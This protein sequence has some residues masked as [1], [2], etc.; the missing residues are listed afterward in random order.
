MKKLIALVIAGIV[1]ISALP[2]GVFAEG[3][4]AEWEI[5]ENYLFYNNDD[6]EK[7]EGYVLGK[8]RIG[9]EEELAASDFPEIEDKIIAIEAVAESDEYDVIFSREKFWSASCSK[10]DIDEFI[11]L[12]KRIKGSPMVYSVE[13]YK[14]GLNEKGVDEYYTHYNNYY[15]YNNE[16]ESRT[17]GGLIISIIDIV[18]TEDYLNSGAY[19]D[20]S[21]LGKYKEKF[22]VRWEQQND[23]VS[24]TYI[25]DGMDADPMVYTKETIDELIPI[26]DYIKRLPFVKYVFPGLILSIDDPV[27]PPVTEPDPVVDPEPKGDAPAEKDALHNPQTDDELFVL[28]AVAAVAAVGASVTGFAMRKKKER[29]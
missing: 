21:L 4:P 6:L 9:A 11:S 27:D 8:V 28:I 12:V 17:K 1:L 15:C 16:S 18:F 10:D 22:E 14:L 13:P 2:L 20:V 26:L 7:K 25:F 29:D 23:V 19:F 24:L 5:Y 3:A